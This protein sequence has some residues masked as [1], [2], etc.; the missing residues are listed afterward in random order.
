M[1]VFGGRFN[2][3]TEEKTRYNFDSFWQSLLTVFQVIFLYQNPKKCHSNAY[4]FQILTGED[5]NVVMYEGIAA[6]GGVE[7]FGVL[8]CIYFIILFICGNCILL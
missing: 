5:W 1:Q 6:Y 8:S 7:S 2:K 4:S 3:D